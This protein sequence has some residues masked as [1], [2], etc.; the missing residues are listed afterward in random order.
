ML[1]TDNFVA[2]PPDLRGESFSPVPS[3]GGGRGE[4]LLVGYFCQAGLVR[5]LLYV[6]KAL[7]VQ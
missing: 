2:I 1:D 3:I 5:E 4:F 7:F 6:L